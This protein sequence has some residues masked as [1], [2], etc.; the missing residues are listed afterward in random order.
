MNI[1]KLRYA[2]SAIGLHLPL[3]F[4]YNDKLRL[5]KVIEDSDA[6]RKEYNKICNEIHGVAR[7]NLSINHSNYSMH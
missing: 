6:L 2:L 1:N 3:T 4:N 5:M 7:I